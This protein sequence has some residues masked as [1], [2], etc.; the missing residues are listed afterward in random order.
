MRFPE[1]PAIGDVNEVVG[2]GGEADIADCGIDGKLDYVGCGD[3][4]CVR[5]VTTAEI[6][7]NE[8]Q[9]A[10][11]SIE[12]PE[13]GASPDVGIIGVGGRGDMTVESESDVR[14]LKRYIPIKKVY[15]HGCT[16][17]VGD[18]EY[19]IGPATDWKD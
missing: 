15:E 10:E 13:R 18:E 19:F 9:K 11:C 6:E 8:A 5:S 17:N 7:D 3:D 1:A 4:S 16:N 14:H 12:C 2:T